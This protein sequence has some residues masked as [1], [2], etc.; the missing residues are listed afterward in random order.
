MPISSE[1]KDLAWRDHVRKQIIKYREARDKANEKIEYWLK[2]QAKLDA[3]KS[4]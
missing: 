2:L 3:G 1:D 4:P